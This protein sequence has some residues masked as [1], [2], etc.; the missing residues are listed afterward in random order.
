MPR[1]SEIANNVSFVASCSLVRGAFFHSTSSTKVLT[2][3][4]LGFL[5]NVISTPKVTAHGVSMLLVFLIF[6]HASV[7]QGR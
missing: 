3:T 6:E 1:G 7:Y 2:M 4:L 5:A